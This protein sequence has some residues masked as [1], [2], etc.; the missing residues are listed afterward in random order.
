[1]SLIDISYFV[2]DINIP[3]TDQ[4]PVQ[5]R[6][7]Y[8]I[9]KYEQEFLRKLLGY[10]LYKAFISSL[11]VIPPAVPEQRMVD[12]LYGKEYTNLQGRLTQWRG[13]ILTDNP[14][15]NLAGEYIFKPAVYLTAG[16][17]IGLT[18]GTTSFTFD[19]TLGRPD[20]RGWT[21]VIFRS[22]PMEPGV[23]YS[24]NP[25]TA[26]LNLLKPGDKFGNG[27]KLF[28]QFELRTDPIDSTDVSPKQSPI[29]NYIYY[30]HRRGQFTKTTDFGEVTSTADNTIN[31]T[32]NEKMASAWNEM[33]DWVCE[34][35]EFMDTYTSQEPVIYPEWQWIY[36]WDT[37]R[38]FEFMNPIF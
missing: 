36:R 27:D 8:A 7:N 33:H 38:H 23:D 18:P 30:W 14:V 32:S 31:R 6:V 26:Q 21:P 13:L 35:I 34:F 29:A 24:W 9:Q 20:W 1:M 37:I 28:V 4:E 10:P 22:A 5:Q 25:D 17:S 19:G 15:F 2:G 11:Q 16:T 3:N 12:I